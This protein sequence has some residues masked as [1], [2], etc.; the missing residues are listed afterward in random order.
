M[1]LIPRIAASPTF[2]KLAPAIIPRVD[3]L[4]HRLSGGRFTLAGLYLPV[5][6]LTTT[7]RKSGQPRQVPIATFPRGDDFVVVGSNYGRE[8]HPAW[9]LNLLANPEATVSYKGETFPVRGRQATDA[10][11]D[12]LWP[13]ITR[14]MPNFDA[15]TKRTDRDIRVFILERV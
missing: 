13:K 14:R 15:Y 8:S 4:V 6:M 9:S 12:E 11:Y 5:L 2:A 7:G 10:E 3:T 1:K